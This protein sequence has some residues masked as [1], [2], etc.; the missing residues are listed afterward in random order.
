MVVARQ[1]LVKPE[2][3]AD[4]TQKEPAPETRALEN[5]CAVQMLSR[6]AVVDVQTTVDCTVV[7]LFWLTSDLA[8]KSASHTAD[9]GTD[10]SALNGTS[11]H[12]TDYSAGASADCC[13]L[14]STCTRRNRQ[15]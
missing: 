4:R 2:F 12:A 10:S 6:G 11:G 13:S 1:T 15:K 8:D 9:G 14:L 5:P 3:P 7:A